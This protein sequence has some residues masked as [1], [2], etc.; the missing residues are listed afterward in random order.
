MARSEPRLKDTGGVVDVVTVV[1]AGPRVEYG[2]RS[3]I[4]A[5]IATQPSLTDRVVFVGAVSDPEL[6]E[7]YAHAALLLYLTTDEGFGLPPLEAFAMSC[8][9]IASDVPSVK[10]VIGAVSSASTRSEER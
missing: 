4:D 1:V 10:E 9:V 3:E 8:P 2:N 7:L 6:F 5:Y